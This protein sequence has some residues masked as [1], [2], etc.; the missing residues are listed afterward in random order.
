MQ[1]SMLTKMDLDMESHNDPIVDRI[2]ALRDNLQ[3]WR[4]EYAVFVKM[5]KKSNRPEL[6]NEL[7]ETIES[8]AED[9]KSETRRVINGQI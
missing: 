5:K 1:I 4:I 2:T 8:I 6:Y 7:L 9:I 3:E